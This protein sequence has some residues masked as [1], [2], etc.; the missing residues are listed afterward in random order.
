M[1]ST[2]DSAKPK[3]SAGLFARSASRHLT[4]P[5][6]DL[7]EQVQHDVELESSADRRRA[8]SRLADH[9][10]A[11]QVRFEMTLD[12]AWDGVAY[13]QLFDDLWTYALPVIKAFLKKNQMG[14]LLERYAPERVITMRSE[15]MV[16]LRNSDDER[17]ALALDIIATA[18]ENFR[19]RA[20]GEH[21]WKASLRNASLRTY[22]IG[23]C[24][25]A[26]PRAYTKWS[27][28]RGGKLELLASQYDISLSDIGG[29]LARDL[30]DPAAMAGL[31]AD[32]KKV[33]DVATPTTKLILGMLAQ[34]MTQ[35]QIADELGLT[36]K[37][38]NRRL[39]HFRERVAAPVRPENGRRP[40]SSKS[41]IRSNGIHTSNRR[42]A[43]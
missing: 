7:L 24:A 10:L 21:K 32:L 23:T 18:V 22:F 37:A 5:I 14:R 4:D 1:P 29:N 20:I 9:H 11:E 33:I 3:G 34:D 12:R 19:D 41:R 2:Y 40:I 36:V 27:K 25:F 17:T 39:A 30:A 42:A 8:E 43:A 15:D 16:V 13:H 28:A 26:Y 6:A 35:V 31:R 38:V